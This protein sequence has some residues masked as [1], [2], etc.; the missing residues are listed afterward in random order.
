MAKKGDYTYKDYATRRLKNERY[1]KRYEKDFPSKKKYS[2]PTISATKK[3]DLGA[4]IKR[5]NKQW[6]Q[7]RRQAF[8]Q[9]F[10]DGM[11]IFGVVLMVLLAIALISALNGGD[12]VVN[13]MSLLEFFQGMQSIPME[14]TFTMI[15]KVDFPDWLAF[16]EILINSLTGLISLGAFGAIGLINC[17]GFLL[18][19]IG[20]IFTV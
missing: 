19:F 5:V 4:Q 12:R 20:F 17:L 1:A 9:G 2:S 8:R 15:P 3:N 7:E 14:W 10:N 18:Q 11:N 13:T 6:K 16:L